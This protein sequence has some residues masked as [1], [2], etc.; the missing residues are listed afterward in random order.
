MKVLVQC[1]IVVV[2]IS[3]SCMIVGGYQVGRK[4]PADANVI[5]NNNNNNEKK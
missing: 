1:S 2:S 3:S 4:L 5:A